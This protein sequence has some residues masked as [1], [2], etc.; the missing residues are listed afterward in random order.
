MGQTDGRIAVSLNA[1][2]PTVGQ[3]IRNF[4]CVPLLSTVLWAAGR[5][6]FFT[7]PSVRAY[8]QHVVM[9]TH[10]HRGILILLAVDTAHMVCRAG[11][12]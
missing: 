6:M 8:L 11:S 5:I 3:G 7:C 1:P 10:S 2:P 12:V 4:K 9:A